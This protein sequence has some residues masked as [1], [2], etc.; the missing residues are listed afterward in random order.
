MPPWLKHWPA[1]VGLLAMGV[2]SAVMAY[3]SPRFG[4]VTLSEDRELS[5]KIDQFLK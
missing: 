5:A 3:R 1:L 4:S 2:A